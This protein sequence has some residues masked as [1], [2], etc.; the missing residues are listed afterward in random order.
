MRKLSGGARSPAK[1]SKCLWMNSHSL[2]DWSATQC[3]GHG[4][5]RER[6]S[7]KLLGHENTSVFWVQVG[8]VAYFST[9]SGKKKVIT[10]KLFLL[11]FLARNTYF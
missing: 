5:P 8:P 11:I 9:L 6:D 7:I 4:R 10:A 2:C 3:P 1:E